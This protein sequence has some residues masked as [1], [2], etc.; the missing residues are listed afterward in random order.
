M[1][2]RKVRMTIAFSADLL[3]AMDSIVRVGVAESRNVFSGG[4]SVGNSRPLPGLGLTRNLPRW[5]TI[6][7]IKKG[8][9]QV[10][11]RPVVGVSLKTRRPPCNTA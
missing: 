6:P 5:Q 11:I 1:S 9:A 3:E 10:G 4:R 8:S 2:A 7:L